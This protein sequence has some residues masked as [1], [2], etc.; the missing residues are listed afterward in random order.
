MRRMYDLCSLVNIIL[1]VYSVD[2]LYANLWWKQVFVWKLRENY[3]FLISKNELS[4]NFTNIFLWGHHAF[5]E[6]YIKKNSKKR[7]FDLILIFNLRNKLYTH[8]FLFVLLCGVCVFQL[9]ETSMKPLRRQ[10]RR[11]VRQYNCRVTGEHFTYTA[12]EL[13]QARCVY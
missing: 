1:F 8:P 9:T 11:Q 4:L 12:V 3:I 13:S 10:G 6:R 2:I 7:S 5:Q